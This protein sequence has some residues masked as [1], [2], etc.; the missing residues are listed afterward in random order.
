[1]DFNARFCLPIAEKLDGDC[2]CRLF[3]PFD[4]RHTRGNLYVSA[5]FVCFDSKVEGLVSVVMPLLEVDSVEECSGG[6]EVAMKNRG[7]L[8]C[9]QNGAAIM[10]SEV[11]DRDKVLARII[12]FREQAKIQ[13]SMLR[14]KKIDCPA[15]DELTTLKD[16]LT[17][18]YPLDKDTPPALTKRWEKLADE[19]GWGVGMYRTVDMHRLLL[20]GIPNH[21]RGQMWLLCSGAGAE[22]GLHPG[23]YENLLRTHHGQFTVAIEEIERDLHRGYSP[24]ESPEHPAFQKGPGI[25]ALR[26]I[27]TAYSFRNPNI[28][29]CQAMNIVG[30]VLLLFVPEE[31]AFWLLV[32][33]CERL[34]PDYYN[35]KVVGAL[36]D[37]GVFSE[38]VFSFLP[39]VHEQLVRMG[40]DQMI[41]LSWFL[42]VF[43][44]D[45]KFNAAV[46]ILDLF[47]FEGAKLMFQV[48][49][50][51]LKENEELLSK[52]KDDGDTMVALSSYTGKV[53]D[54][55]AMADGKILIG[56][57]LT[58][59]YRDFGCAFTNEQIEK[60]RLKHRL[61]VVQGL[62]D[63]QMRSIIKSVGRECKF[64]QDE[65]EKLYNLIKEEHLLSWRARLAMAA[66][67]KEESMLERSAR[68][69]SSTQ[70][71]VDFELFE[72]IVPRLLPWAADHILIVRMFRLL[73]ITETGL[74]TFRDIAVT[75]SIVLRGDPTEKLAFFY[76][77][78][79]PPAFNDSDLDDVKPICEDAHNDF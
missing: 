15:T 21:R 2:E 36:V 38:L 43:L 24:Q 13:N 41:A 18:T 4:R 52:S 10:F 51:I 64:S 26:R 46:R 71:R 1:M 62:E 5:N 44:S 30:S 45:I 8:I 37:Q 31:E 47:F 40:L 73:D 54:T 72:Q 22:M 48:A 58:N 32:A 63:S 74:L 6:T 11:P 28:G 17:T 49:L 39:S 29:Y 76:K 69:T 7:I 33:V 16:P 78:H 68:G 77:C 35:T 25:G 57:L 79:L 23:Y 59:S 42:T 61:K 9:L 70:Y 34:L 14:S 27:L 75:L 65:L 66:R 20:D 53:V 50:E 56:D 19:Y 12:A 55:E 60:L 67:G 3:T